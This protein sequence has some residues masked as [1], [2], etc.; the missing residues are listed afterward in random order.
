MDQGWMVAY[1][2][3]WGEQAGTLQS[4][5][6]PSVLIC[7]I[8]I[9]IKTRPVVRFCTQETKRSDPCTFVPL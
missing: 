3:V 6:R 7:H 8:N 4:F 5:L 9:P 1:V 2:R